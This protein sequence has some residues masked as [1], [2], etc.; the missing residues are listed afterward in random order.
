MTCVRAFGER[1]LRGAR[2]A[3]VS[4]SA[5]LVRGD[6]IREGPLIRPYG[7]PSPQGEKGRAALEWMDVT[8]QSWRSRRR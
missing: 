5:E 8:R 1:D 4:H 7:A 6:C 3:D 2:C